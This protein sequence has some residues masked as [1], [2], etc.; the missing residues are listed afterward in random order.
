MEKKSVRLFSSHPAGHPGP[1]SWTVKPGPRP[2]PQ[3]GT[4]Q[5]P[6]QQGTP[7]GQ[8]LVLA[9]ALGTTAQAGEVKPGRRGRGRPGGRLLSSGP[10]GC[11]RTQP[12]A[13]PTQGHPGAHACSPVI[14]RYETAGAHACSPIIFHICYKAA[15]A[16]AC[17]PV[18]FAMRLQEPIHART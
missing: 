9:H 11:F 16:H 1:W 2:L 7:I 18:R 10:R 4:P 12:K 8:E 6:H 15:G 5:H 14:F 17:S 13:K 3:R